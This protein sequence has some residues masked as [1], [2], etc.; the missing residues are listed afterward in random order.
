MGD[1][2]HFPTTPPLSRTPRH[3]S[4]SS[5]ALLFANF[6][7]QPPHFCSF[8]ILS[9]GSFQ[10][11]ALLSRLAPLRQ[12]LCRRPTHPRVPRRRPGQEVQ[13][14]VK[15]IKDLQSTQAALTQSSKALEAELGAARAKV[16][17]YT[18]ELDSRPGHPGGQCPRP[19][20]PDQ[21]S[22]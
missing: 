11:A 10:D 2:R 20:T 12:R 8:T 22:I 9:S 19:L 15:V 17:E 4:T 14:F 7:F 18:A 3:P 21:T 5:S 6:R 1:S 16:L 13:T